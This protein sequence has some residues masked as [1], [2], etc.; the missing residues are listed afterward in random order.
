M[1]DNDWA[2]DPDGLVALAHHL[3]SP[4]NDVRAV[5]S[6]PLNPF[7]G[8]P[9][10]TAGVGAELAAELAGLLGATIEGG[11]HAGPDAPFTGRPRP[12]AAADAIVAEARRDD[13]MPLYLVCAGPLTNVAD[14]LLAEPTLA[15]SLV[16][17]WVGG[18]ANPDDWEYNRATDEDAATF[19]LRTRATV[20]QFPLEA[21]RTARI[22]VAELE[23]GLA[24]SGVVGAWLWDRFVTLP[25]PEGVTLGEVWALGDSLPL[26]VTALGRSSFEGLPLTPGVREV[27]A[28]DVRLLISDLFAKLRRA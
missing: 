8:P 11:V 26:L 20:I 9:D 12:N 14:A 10:G 13:R 17:V 7:F 27:G 2:G 28:D 15:D 4:S 3:L 22:A 23:Q 18:T 25:L 16:I 6:S 24:D 1:I 5:T 21:Y 19:V